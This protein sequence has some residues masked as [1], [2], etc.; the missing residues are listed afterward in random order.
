MAATDR[1]QAVEVYAMGRR[2]PDRDERLHNEEL[3][4][5]FGDR[6]RWL[7][8]E[9]ERR[10]PGYWSQ[11]QCA[12]YVGVLVPKYSRWECGKQLP[13]LVYQRR[14]MDVFRV[15][16]NYLL[17]GV[18]DRHLPAW[19]REALRSAHAELQSEESF[20]AQRESAYAELTR[21]LRQARRPVGR[22]KD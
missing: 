17:F 16:P 19:L 11:R 9:H 14:I 8:E 1:V 13:R 5:G 2:P 20:Y 15:T 12:D 10:E 3:M 22:Q 7:R 4:L 21:Q 18:L 6:L